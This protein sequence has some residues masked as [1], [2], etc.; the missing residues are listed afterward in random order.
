M[1]NYKELIEEN[2]AWLEETF[3]KVD[4]KLSKVTLRSRD[5]LVDGVGEDGKTHR[6]VNPL[7]W[8]SG[9][10]G[11]MNVLMYIACALTVISG[12]IYIYDYREY[13]DPKK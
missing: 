9:F 4:N 6:S 1:K 10:W 2:R 7:G 8:T 11:G 12:V 5:K 13:I 3:K